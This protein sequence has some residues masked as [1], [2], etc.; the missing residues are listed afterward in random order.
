MI[1]QFNVGDIIQSNH[2]LNQ[3]TIFYLI[4]DLSITKQ[5]YKVHN[6]AYDLELYFNMNEN[7]HNNYEIVSKAQ[8]D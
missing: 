2:R 1:N 5:L 4:T 3:H 8:R 6:I 7:T